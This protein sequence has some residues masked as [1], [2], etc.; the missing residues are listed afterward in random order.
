MT[1][2]T[3]EAPGAVRLLS[4]VDSAGRPESYRAHLHRLGPLPARLSMAADE[5]LIALTEASGLLGR[6]G[7]GFP[8]GRKM[9]SVA[10]GDKQPI[11][12]ANGMEGEPAARKDALLMSRLPHLVL[13]G[14]VLAARAVGAADG[15]L[16]VHSGSPALPM[17]RRAL[18]ERDGHADGVRIGIEEV[19]KRYVSSEESSLVNWLNGGSAVPLFTPPRPY[20]K[21][22]HGRPT[23]IQNAETLAH[24]A[25]IA[26]GGADWFR[27][28]GPADE[29]G[30]LLVSVGG[31]VARPGVLEVAMGTP[32]GTVLSML[33]ARPQ[34]ISAVLVGGYFGGWLP[35][36]QAWNLPLSHAALKSVGLG[37]GAG[38]VLALPAGACGLIE[39]ARVARYLAGE[40]AGQCGP[41][42]HGLPAIADAMTAV[43]QGSKAAA[44]AIAAIERWSS[45]VEG[46]GACRMPDGA[47]RFVASAWGA[48]AGDVARHSRFGSCPGVRHPP[49][50]P[51]P[52]RGG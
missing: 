37:L 19:P 29:P 51:L 45:L 3:V 7:A 22:V 13:D 21:G 20:E 47:V 34:E 8:T 9:R 10:A 24:L 4:H 6:G 25:M 43:A 11:L 33:G 1:A 28:V 36:A 52:S 15:H 40:T 48:F 35:L 38:I 44:G 17:L 50:L 31:A 42:Q 30:S 41:C 23:L 14:M 39:T 26:R 27:S 32:I 46:R 5:R 18:S 2:A 49:V 16:C 12:V